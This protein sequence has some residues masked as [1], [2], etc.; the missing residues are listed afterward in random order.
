MDITKEYGVNGG[1]KDHQ[2][3]K[4]YLGK[5]KTI[6]KY[7]VTNKQIHQKSDASILFLSAF[8]R[9]S[10]MNIKR[11]LISYKLLPK[12]PDGSNLPPR[13][14]DLV[15][16]ASL[17]VRIVEPGYFNIAGFGESNQLMQN[18]QRWA[19]TLRYAFGPKSVA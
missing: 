19:A 7:L 14:A 10:Q 15:E 17:E 8:S 1:I 16:A 2:E 4:S 11:T 13:W 3:F 18:K 12:G 9:E 6:L 5:F